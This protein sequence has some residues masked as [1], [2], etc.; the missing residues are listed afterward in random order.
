MGRLNDLDN[1]LVTIPHDA[2]AVA[3][4]WG[5]KIR[6][7]ADNSRVDKDTLKMLVCCAFKLEEITEGRASEI[8]GIHQL[9]F[10]KIF[11]EWEQEEEEYQE[12]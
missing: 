12:D 11:I 3:R 2:N 4:A 1:E 9:D 10:R 8:L 6:Q 5:H 7:L